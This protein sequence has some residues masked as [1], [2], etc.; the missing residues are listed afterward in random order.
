M[1]KYLLIIC[2]L[3]LLV[4][5]EK[6]PLKGYKKITPVF[7][8]KIITDKDTGT[9]SGHGVYLVANAVVMTAKDSAVSDPNLGGGFYLQVP[10]RKPVAGSD[11]M[12]GFMK[13]SDGDSAVFL[14]LADTFFSKLNMSMPMPQ[15]VKSGDYVKMYVQVYSLLDSN[16]YVRWQEEKEVQDKAMARQ[17]F[18]AY[19]RTAGITQTADNNGIIRIV[20]REGK[21]T[22]PQ[23]GDTVDVHYICLTMSGA[24][25]TNTYMQGNPYRFVLGSHDVVEGFNLSL[26]KMKKGEKSRLVIPYYLA[27]GAE[28]YDNIVPPYTHLIMDVELMDIIK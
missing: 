22:S 8:Y 18:D 20:E 7:G 27:Y 25:L 28:G 5:C 26:I 14:M 4:A 13:L 10:L 24:E 12:K 17:I 19:L 11:L 9:A 1:K 2:S 15:N 21:G 6:G 3:I 23:Y 16:E